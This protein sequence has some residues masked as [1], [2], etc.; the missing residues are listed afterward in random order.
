M[1]GITWFDA[2][3]YCEWAGLRLPTEAEWEKAAS[4]TDGR[5]Y[6]W[7]EGLDRSK[8]NY[9]I[10]NCCGGDDSDGYFNP[11]PV[12]SYPEGISPYG[13]YD[14][15]GNV[16]QWVMDWFDPG[17]Y[18]VSP[19]HNPI[20]PT[21]GSEKVLRGGAWDSQERSPRVQNR[22]RIT[23]STATFSVGLRCARDP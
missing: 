10:A 4:G 2:K 18:S 7:G 6:P 16:W 8:L 22:N 9:G 5:T 1:V 13:A 14:M 23:P 3:A 12:G 11:A 17:Y 20:G 21:N 15:A 19:D